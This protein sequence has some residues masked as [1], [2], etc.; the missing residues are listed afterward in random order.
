MKIAEYS[1]LKKF[2]TYKLCYLAVK[3]HG[4]DN[5]KNLEYYISKCP[6]QYRAKLTKELIENEST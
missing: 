3:T 6:K 2:L 1:D 4:G 5:E